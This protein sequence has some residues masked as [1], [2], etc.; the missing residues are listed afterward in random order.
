MLVSPL[1]GNDPP[2]WDEANNR[3]VGPT[4]YILIDFSRFT[5]GEI[6]QP[7]R[8]VLIYEDPSCHDQPRIA[9]G[10]CDGHVESMTRP[11]FRAALERTQKFLTAG[12]K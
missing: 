5:E 12:K 7:S 11:E 10:F 6:A 8:M 1:S 3:W 4:D 9:V 2:R